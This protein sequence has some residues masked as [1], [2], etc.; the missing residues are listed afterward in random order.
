MK[1]ELD[2]IGIAVESLATGRS[3][4]EALGLGP[5][6]QERVDSEK[7]TVGFFELDNDARLE[8][9]E[10]TDGESTVAKF[11]R[12]RGPGIHHICL[13][14]EDIA[15]AIAALKAKGVQMIHDQPKK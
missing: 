7:V 14:V 5:M 15:G 3:F 6:V 12:H 1:F 10:P 8:L 13:K 2:H 11:L 4:Y 9:L